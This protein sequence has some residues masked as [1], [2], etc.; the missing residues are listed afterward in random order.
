MVSDSWQ[1]NDPCSF[2]GIAHPC[3]EVPLDVPEARA[4]WGTLPCSD[5]TACSFNYGSEGWGE[6]GFI[7]FIGR[8]R[9]CSDDS[10]RLLCA[11]V[12]IAVQSHV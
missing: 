1:C 2:S 6:M 8:A 5:D 3:K 4:P 11:C 7:P 10:L 9:S 12:A